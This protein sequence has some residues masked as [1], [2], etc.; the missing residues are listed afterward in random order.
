MTS[1]F[2]VLGS[3]MLVL[4]TIPASARTNA[5]GCTYQRPVIEYDRS[6]YFPADEYICRLQ[7]TD[8]FYLARHR[9]RNSRTLQ[10][11]H[12][13]EPESARYWL[14]QNADVLAP[15]RGIFPPHAVDQAHA[16]SSGLSLDE[17]APSKFIDS[18]SDAKIEVF[19]ASAIQLGIFSANFWPP[20]RMAKWVRGALKAGP[21]ARGIVRPV[22]VQG[23][24]NEH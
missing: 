11:V 1:R 5:P 21:D 12:F 17:P 6:L 23:V 9:F 19:S 3:M 10:N 7:G 13:D 16:G 18:L 20:F 4:W 8:E 22:P 24:R 14:S 2:C 15:V